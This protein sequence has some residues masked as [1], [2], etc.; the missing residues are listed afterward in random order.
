[1]KKN[2]ILFTFLISLK[3]TL[4]FSQNTYF[5]NLYLIN[6]THTAALSITEDNTTSV[7]A[8]VSQ[9]T[10]GFRIINFSRIDNTGNIIFSKNFG[11]TTLNFFPGYYDNL[12]KTYNNNFIISCDIQDANYDG[13]KGLLLK[14]SPSFDTIFTKTWEDTIN[15][16]IGFNQVIETKDNGYIIVGGKNGSGSYNVD[17]LIIKTDSLGNEQWKK[18]INLG[19]I[20]YAYNVIQTTDNGYLLGCYSY[21]ATNWYSGDGKIIKIDSLGN[22]QWI[23]TIGGPNNDAIPIV[24]LANDSNYLVATSYA[25]YSYPYREGSLLKTQV[26]KIDKLN[27]NIIWDKQYDTIRSEIYPHMIKVA[28]NGEIFIL[29]ICDDNREISWFLKLDNNGDSIYYRKLYKYNDLDP[30]VNFIGNTVTDFYLNNNNSLFISGYVSSD[31]SY[32]KV[33][34]LR[35]DS[36]GCLEPGCTNVGIKEIKTI[37]TELK[38]FPNPATNQTTLV[39][40]QLKEEGELQIYSTMGQLVYEEKLVKASSQKEINIQNF[41]AGL[42]KVIIREKGIIKGQVGLIKN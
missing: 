32:Q 13:C 9:D 36:S 6:N 40:P 18:A 42:Y 21:I 23:K 11:Q 27:G 24:A 31:T 20:E 3:V 15:N 35:M 22:T 19:G 25:Y 17:I 28:K 10:N 34:L 37:I 33:W 29:G 41:K 38:L 5:N 39:F 1:M 8:S 7:V 30:L 16:F 12:H 4:T 2:I 26:V 14:L